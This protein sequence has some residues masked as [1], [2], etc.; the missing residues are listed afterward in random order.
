MN[1]YPLLRRAQ[2]IRTGAPRGA[3]H[4]QRG[5]TMIE[6][7]VGLTI[8]TILTTVGVPSFRNFIA[9]QS[10]VASTNDL[11]GALNL[12]R[13]EALKLARHVTVCKSNDGQ[14]CGGASVDWS[15]GW[16]VFANTS[17]SNVNVHDTDEPLIRVFAP[18]DDRVTLASPDG[19]DGAIAFRPTGDLDVSGTLVYCDGRGDANARGVTVARSGRA[20]VS[21]TTINDEALTCD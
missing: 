18:L 13:S 3:R 7:M 17:R 20:R 15:D 5:L 4:A 6:L 14:S 8:V 11:V 21:T 10:R 1:P 9:D 2:A 12:A 16:I 19:L